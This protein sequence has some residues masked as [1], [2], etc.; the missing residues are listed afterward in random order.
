[1]FR[2]LI[3]KP[4]FTLT[5]VV[6]GWSW[7]Y[8]PFEVLIAVLIYVGLEG[9]LILF[10]IQSDRQSSPPGRHFAKRLPR[11]VL[12]AGGMLAI[13][14]LYPAMMI[15]LVLTAKSL[16][17]LVIMNLIAAHLLLGW[18]LEAYR[19][20]INLQGVG[21]KANRAADDF[22]RSSKTS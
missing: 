7:I 10:A 1:M 16:L 20:T 6:I 5:L 8:V 11:I 3:S 12:L 19:R 15:L 17:P 22:E 21:S 18:A 14:A 4:L 9:T 2:F 13:G